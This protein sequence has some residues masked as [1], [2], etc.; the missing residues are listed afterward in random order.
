MCL[1]IQSSCVAVMRVIIRKVR[2]NIQRMRVWQYGTGHKPQT[3]KEPRIPPKPC[4]FLLMKW[5][6]SPPS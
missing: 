1:R 6:T 2:L 3:S 4:R 5:T